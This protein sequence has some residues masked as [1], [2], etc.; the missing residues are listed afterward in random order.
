MR[1]APS[2]SVVIVSRNEGIHLRDTVS[3]FLASVPDDAEIIVVDDCSTDRSVRRIE[4]E[5]RVR[6]DRTPKWIGTVRARNFGANR[7]RGAVIVFA[8]AHVSVPSAWWETLLEPLEDPRVGAVGPVI[9]GLNHPEAKGYGLRFVDAALNC[10]W[11][12]WRGDDPH[13]V[14]LLGAG[15]M[16]MRRDLF[17]SLGGFDP[18]MVRYGMEDPDLDLRLWTYGYSCVLV[19]T[20]EV[21]HLFRADHPFQSWESFLHNVI[22]FGVV[23]FGRKRLA[24]LLES[25]ASDPALP[26]ALARV[27][28]SDVFA[29][30]ESV[31]ATRIR[32]A[33]W[34]F[35]EVA[36]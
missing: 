18:G 6:I 16:A 32:D 14:P 3:S 8:D 28:T 20:V 22:R 23:H 36:A 17:A 4:A 24:A 2:I 31:R 35:A 9:Q 15:L 19:P 27:M 13:P 21:G 30:R 10:E 12:L 1:D 7:A 33:E 25:Y 11:G 29:R 26:G 34:Y 5:T